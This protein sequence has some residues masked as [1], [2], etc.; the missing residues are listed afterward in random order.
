[1]SKLPTSVLYDLQSSSNIFVPNALV[2]RS[3]IEKKNIDVKV[4]NQYDE[5]NILKI[6]KVYKEIFTNFICYHWVAKYVVTR[7]RNNAK[8]VGHCKFQHVLVSHI[9]KFTPSMCTTTYKNLKWENFANFFDVINV[10]E[11]T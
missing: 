4:E 11:M 6:D 7:V 8:E 3:K 1:M 10:I 2:L 5:C 9:L